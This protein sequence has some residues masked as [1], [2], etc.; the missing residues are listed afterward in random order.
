MSEEKKLTDEEIIKALQCC[1]TENREN[2]PCLDC[3]YFIKH[4]DC[5][6][7]RRHEKDLLDLINRQKAEIERLSEEKKTLVWLNQSL[8]KKVDE[9]KAGNTELYKENTTLIAGSILERKDI[10]KDTAKEICLKIIKGQPKPIKERWV[11]WFKKEYGV[12]VDYE[13]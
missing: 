13:N 1:A 12:E 10:A 11:E 3:P 4:I 7:R 8:E 2:K 9:L 6:P 5:V